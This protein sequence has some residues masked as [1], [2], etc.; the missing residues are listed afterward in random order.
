MDGGMTALARPL[1]GLSRVKGFVFDLDGTLVLP[2]KRA[3]DYVV[4]PGA[5]EIVALLRSRGI[6]FLA[7]TNNSVHTPA[8]CAKAVRVAGLDLADEEIVTPT[9]VAA[10][11]FTRRKFRRVLVLGREGMRVP[12]IEAGLE[13]VSAETV[14]SDVDAVYVGYHAGFEMRE[15][16]AACAAVWAGARL[17]VSSSAPFFATRAGRSIGVERAIA[18]AIASITR[19]RW[20]VVGKPSPLALRLASLRLGVPIADLAVVGDDPD[21]EIGMARRG[22]AYAIAVGSGVAGVA[23]FTTRHFDRQP[24]LFLGNI[25]ELLRMLT[26]Y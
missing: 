12:L 3:G 4:L 23:D 7:L 26:R 17:F 24:H 6:P 8:S 19:K 9:V 5:A 25:G 18:A 16:E 2:D 10:G 11:Y 20:T 13:V 21:L 22:G 1:D 14:G 15:L